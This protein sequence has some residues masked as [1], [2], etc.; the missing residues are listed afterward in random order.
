[1]IIYL[2]S[3]WQEEW[4]GSLGFWN[5]QTSEEPG[6]LQKEITPVFNRAVLFDTTCNSWH[7]LPN[8]IDCPQ[9]EC[10]KSI[11]VYYLV[12]PQ[13]DTD[14]RAKALFAPSEAQ[15][16]DQDVLDLIKLR[17]SGDTAHHVYK[18]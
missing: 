11:A 15:K 18:K 2:N 13:Q 4:G 17:A 14:P 9:D 16:D 6:D 12:T 7:G 3:R 1:M 10:R 5:N 8:P